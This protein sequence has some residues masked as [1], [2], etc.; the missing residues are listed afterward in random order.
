M[1]FTRNW[2]SKM[3]AKVV[4]SCKSNKTSLASKFSLRNFFCKRYQKRWVIH[5]CSDAREAR[6]QNRCSSVCFS[7]SIIPQFF[8][9]RNYKWSGKGRW[10]VLRRVAG[11]REYPNKP[12]CMN[13]RKTVNITGKSVLQLFL[14]AILSIAE[15]ASS[16]L[17]KAVVNLT[18]VHI[19]AVMV[20]PAR[21]FMKLS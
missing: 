3:F 20:T 19:L 9:W 1:L 13:N 14:P 2:D 21:M 6:C 16:L 10:I 18:T 4:W 5:G 17:L 15:Q 11:E 8:T 12:N 7:A